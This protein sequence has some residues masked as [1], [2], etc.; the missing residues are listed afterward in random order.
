MQF[1]DAQQDPLTT[2]IAKS[3]VMSQ[4]G[5]TAPVAQGLQGIKGVF[6]VRPFH[7]LFLSAT[8][9]CCLDGRVNFSRSGGE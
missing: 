3:S 6:E 8:P 4:G 2:M 7:V 5:G 9:F 1:S